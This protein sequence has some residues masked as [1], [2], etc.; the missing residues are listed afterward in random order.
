MT[1]DE[2][3]QLEKERKAYVDKKSKEVI[4]EQKVNNPQQDQPQSIVKLNQD[5]KD[6][7]KKVEELEKKLNDSSKLQDDFT[8]IQ[9]VKREVQYMSKVRNAAGTVVIN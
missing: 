9:I 5:I 3:K 2:L 6:L 4:D 7:T 8:G 1:K